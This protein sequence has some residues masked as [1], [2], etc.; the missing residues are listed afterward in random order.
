VAQ[1]QGGRRHDGGRRT[2]IT[3]AGQDVEHNVSGVDALDNRFGARR[4]DG[5]QPVGDH[6]AKDTD[7][8][9]IA[10][11]GADQLAPDALHRGW[12]YPVLEGS[13]VA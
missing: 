13:A 9:P 4:L 11:V 2:R 5:R 10:V 8:L 6:R 3:L 12:Q 7:Y 1:R